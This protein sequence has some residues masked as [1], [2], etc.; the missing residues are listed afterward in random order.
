MELGD[1]RDLFAQVAA[2]GRIDESDAA[3][4]FGQILQG[5]VF[6]HGMGICHR[7]L[8][9][10]NVLL[11]SNGT[12]K[13]AD[14]GMSKDFSQ[15]IVETRT[16]IGTLAYLAP[17]LFEDGEAGY[18]PEP[19]DV[20]ALGIMLFTMTVGNYPFGTDHVYRGMVAFCCGR[21][22]AR[23]VAELFT[24]CCANDVFQADAWFK[25]HWRGAIA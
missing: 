3:K 14:F 13:V 7:D 1:G 10:E 23:T 25:I 18:S 12:V 20:W 5:V 11:H 9:L 21:R 19:V 6:V 24:T 17:E 2:R 8:K 22:V 15:S 4:W 16:Q